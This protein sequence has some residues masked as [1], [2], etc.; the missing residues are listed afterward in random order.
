MGYQKTDFG[1]FCNKL[2]ID[3]NELMRDMAKRLC[4][5]PSFLSKVEC[6]NSK[7]PM[8]W[9]EKIADLY[10][11]TGEQQEELN[12]V[13][14]LEHTKTNLDISAFSQRDKN[15][16]IAF[17]NQLREMDDSKKE[18]WEEILN[19][20]KKANVRKTKTDFGKFCKKLRIDNNE[21]VQ[22][23][24]LKLN[25]S[26][27]YLT[28][29]ERGGSKPPLRWKKE[30]S[31]LYALTKEQQE[32]LE[33]Y[34]TQE[35][36]KTFNKLT[37]FGVFCRKLRISR[38]ESMIDMAKRLS[39]SHLFLSQAENGHCKPP[40]NWKT[41][42]ASVYELS[43]N[44]QEELAKCIDQEYIKSFGDF[45]DF[46]VFCQ[47][48]GIAREES[49]S[50]MAKRISVSERALY[51]AERGMSRPCLAWKATIA[52][53]YALT[54]EQQ[55]ELSRCIDKEYEKEFESLTDFGKFCREL[56]GI[57]NESMTSMAKR[58]GVSQSYLSNIEYGEPT[59]PLEWK[60][61]IADEYA[62]TKE[63][64]EELN[65]CINLARAK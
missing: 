59:P 9:R 48:I 6:G 11:L 26:K 5:S 38:N 20:R 21:S 64:Q 7:P 46:G 33:K 52:S 39:V 19:I 54:K 57:Q 63:Q 25:V 18:K 31:E 23:M 49:I 24:A 35:Y 27:N 12:R 56:R 29:I 30:L 4:I 53:A 2:R 55:E 22:D 44:Q 28:M 41:K 42:I 16:M 58:L 17:M 14:D 61:I 51:L 50:D 47:K 34:I 1:K 3:N 13:I 40:L 45:S 60:K 32:E 37:D 10:T 65:R 62:L 15:M 36:K 43:E 8:K